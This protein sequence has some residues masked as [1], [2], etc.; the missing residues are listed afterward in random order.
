MR[1]KIP[2]T[3]A[4]MAFDASAR[5]ESFTKAAHELALTQSA[6]CRQVAGL[7]S[8]LGVQLF[9]RSKRGVTLTDA[10]RTYSRHVALRLNAV[11]RDTLELMAHRGLGGTLELAVLPTFATRWLIPRLARF[12][13]VHPDITVNLT[14]STRPFL[15]NGTDFDAAIHCGEAVWPG[16]RADT[17]M[18]ENLVAVCSPALIA[19]HTSLDATQLQAYPLLQQTTRPYVW[20]QWFESQGLTVEHDM[21]GLRFELFSMLTHAAIHQ[22]GVALVPPF[23]VEDELKAGALC[24]PVSHPFESG[25]TYRLLYPEGK[26]E[27]STLNYFR[28]WLADEAL[29]YLSES[30]NIL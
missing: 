27:S 22:M 21:T 13:R 17:L 19:P 8:F 23:L 18:R 9:H 12:Q 20:R 1:R 29:R 26:A 11:E 25:N 28:A 3:W 5:H 30:G 10:G 7:E 2:N 24:M 14:T 4:L 15:F 16:V 6:I